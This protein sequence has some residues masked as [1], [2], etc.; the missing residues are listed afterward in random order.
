PIGG[1]SRPYR[2]PGGWGIPMI[3]SGE[4]YLILNR[5]AEASE[6]EGVAAG[7]AERHLQATLEQHGRPQPASPDLSQPG[8][9]TSNGGT[10]CEMGR[11]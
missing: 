11:T 6:T 1:P 3:E 5:P 2:T 4:S 9:A 8:I 10:I 7:W